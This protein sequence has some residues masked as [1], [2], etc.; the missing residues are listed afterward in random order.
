MTRLLRHDPIRAAAPAYRCD[1][2]RPEVRRPTMVTFSE[3][4]PIY[5]SGAACAAD[6]LSEE[7]R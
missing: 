5:L 2:C 1:K 7:W 3:L 6:E 4:L